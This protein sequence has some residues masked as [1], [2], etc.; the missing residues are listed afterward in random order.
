[1]PNGEL[2]FSRQY[3]N[4][5]IARYVAEAA[6]KDLLRTGLAQDER[7]AS[8]GGG[9][10]TTCADGCVVRGDRPPARSGFRRAERTP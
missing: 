2:L 9:P 6:R 1:M 5:P 10:L 7:M 4:E 8:G 3:D